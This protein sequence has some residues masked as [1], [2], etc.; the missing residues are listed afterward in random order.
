LGQPHV[1]VRFMVIDKAENVKKAVLYYA[2]FVTI[3]SILCMIAA[4]C[5]RVLLPELSESDP[6]LA[7]PT[8]SANLMPEILSGLFLAGLFAAAMSTADSQVL[9]SSA[10]LTHDLFP[11]YKDNVVWSKLGTFLVGLLALGIAISGDKNVMEL[12]LYGWS[13]MAAGMGP[14]LF[15]YALGQK[16]SQIHAVAMMIGGAAVSVGWEQA[17]L[18]NDLYSVLPGVATSLLIYFVPKIAFY[19]SKK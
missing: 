17:G 1:M 19:A 14:L 6:E 5:A 7:L 18:S 15:V 16:P 3:L 11:R 10:A 12:A 8:L 9:S 13:V 4:L 2:G